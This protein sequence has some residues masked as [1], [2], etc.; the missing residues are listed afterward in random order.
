VPP[1]PPRPAPIPPSTPQTHRTDLPPNRTPRL[2]QPFP[3][4]PPSP[5]PT[6]LNTDDD[7]DEDLR[8]ALALSRGE[9][10]SVDEVTVTEK[11]VEEDTGEGPVGDEGEN[12]LRAVRERSVRGSGVPP[13]SPLV[14]EVGLPDVDPRHAGGSSDGAAFGPSNRVDKDGEY[15]M[16]PASLVSRSCLDIAF[17]VYRHRFL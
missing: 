3:L 2:S 7:D 8:K 11:A 17:G 16:V 14:T 5:T 6:L 9:P 12:A 10:I 13:P 4:P 1:L 15:A